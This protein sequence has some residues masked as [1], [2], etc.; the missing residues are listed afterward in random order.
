MKIAVSA[1]GRDLSAQVDPRFGRA[2]YFVVVDA[3][4]LAVEAVEN[5]QNLN[6]PQGA[7]IQ[8]AKNVVAT[9]AR[10][11][12][13]GH[14]GPKAYRVLDAA[15]IPV[16]V[17]AQGTV[18]EAVEAYRNGSLVPASGPDVEEHWV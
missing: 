5:T 12:L 2:A 8:A 13:T 17:G 18:A 7:G 1:A 16:A 10:V 11:L 6:L 9:G 15:G 14:C 3:E 4:T